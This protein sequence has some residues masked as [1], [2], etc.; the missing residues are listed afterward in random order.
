MRIHF[1]LVIGLT[2]LT[3]CT[4]VQDNLSTST[5]LRRIEKRPKRVILMIGDGMGLQ[6]ITAG[7]YKNNDRLNLEGVTSV[8]F[9]KSYSA[10]ELIADSAASGTA[11][12]SGVKTNNG[13]IGLDAEGL[14]T[15]S[16]L[17]EAKEK[18]IAT[19]LVT[20]A[21]LTHATPAAF[22]AH[23]E[24]REDQESLAPFYL[25]TEVDFL[26]GGGKKYFTERTDGRNLYQELLDK[27]YQVSDYSKSAFGKGSFGFN[28][29]FAFFLADDL[30]EHVPTARKDLI[31]ACK[32]APSF[33]KN[34]AEGRF[35][36]MIEDA[37]IEKGGITNDADFIVEEMIAFDQ[38]IGEI[39]KFARQDRETLVII[40]G[41]NETG[42]FAINPGSTRDTLLGFFVSNQP[43]ASL[44]PVFAYGP[45]AKLFSGIY[46]NT[47]IYRKI[48]YALGL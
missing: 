42:G 41:D 24:S 23:S 18:G 17:K 5:P 2:L 39:L 47:D 48:K 46:E 22:V 43:T 26:V 37:Q 45:G 31:T 34:H 30:P 25:E 44:I 6:Q 35:F 33:L 9:H 15:T 10:D 12:A 16:L 14:P 3:A 40:T 11:M 7:M 38:A 4:P 1:F 27:G 19:G 32:L 36:L 13:Y 28:K 8:G 29:N 21:A 20:N